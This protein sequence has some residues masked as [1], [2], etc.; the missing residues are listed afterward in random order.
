MNNYYRFLKRLAYSILLLCSIAFCGYFWIKHKWKQTNTDAAYNSLVKEIEAA[1]Q[2][3]KN[4]YDLSTLTVSESYQNST[5]G[6]IV[7]ISFS[8]LYNDQSSSC[9]C[10]D[11]NYGFVF[12][13][14]HRWS[15][16]INLDEDVTPRKCFDY[17][18]QYFDF[19]NNAIGIRQASTIYFGEDL[20]ALPKVKVLQLL[21]MMENPVLYN[22]KTNYKNNMEK[23]LV[24]LIGI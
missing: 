4:V 1:E 8:Q 22:V 7:N 6:L 20:E 19:L 24:L 3:P 23:T 12:S 18:V 16:G 21:V 2:L 5:L 10:V 9:P 13:T 11:V 14:L 17:Y 15:V